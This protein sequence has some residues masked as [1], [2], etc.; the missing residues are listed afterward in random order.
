MLELL[1]STG[2][3]PFS[4]ALAVVVLL[5]ALQVVGLGDLAAG[6]VDVDV[7]G[8]M[9]VD[10]GLMSL[11]GLGRIPFQMWL[12]ILLSLFGVV[13]LVGQSALAQ[14]TGSALS[15][16]I[17]GPV[18]AAIGLAGT[19]YVSRPLSR[20]LPRDETTAIDLSALIG[21]EAQIVIGTARPGHPARA[22]TTD[23][24][25]QVHHVMVEPDN[26]GQAFVE[27]EKILLVRR[28][29]DVFKAITRGDHY[30]PRL[31]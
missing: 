31:D 27:N 3:T 8:D 14:M 15:P 29:G 13:G 17:A 16:W 30:L 18:A 2:N 6:D 26:P 28:D 20:I 1:T 19:G 23:H 5:A 7:D 25:G 24:F 9:P 10:A 11:V 21:R 4:V 12:M 22:R